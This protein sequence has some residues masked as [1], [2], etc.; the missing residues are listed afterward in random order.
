MAEP[1]AKKNVKS[2]KRPWEQSYVPI[3]G[4]TQFFK[5]IFRFPRAKSGDFSV[6][7]VL[8]NA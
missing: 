3:L 2:C 5:Y 7:A 1:I 4:K 6:T 8:L